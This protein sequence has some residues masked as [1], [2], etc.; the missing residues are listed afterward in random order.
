[1][2]NAEMD[3]E[4]FELYKLREQRR[5]Q[6]SQ[7]VGQTLVQLSLKLPVY[8]K[9]PSGADGL[10]AWGLRQLLELLSQI[11][12]CSHGHDRL[13]PWALL[14]TSIAADRL[15]R[16]TVEL[17]NAHP[18]GLLLDIAVYDRDGYEYKRQGLGLPQRK[19]LI[20]AE[21]AHD[22]LN[23][24][25]HSQAELKARTKKLLAPFRS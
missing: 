13:G 20:C 2:L 24:N 19:C 4:L 7:Q 12:S 21:P 23:G 25:R 11:E 6:V 18:A 8:A 10:F 15:K 3:S 5:L 1:M 14:G 22:C 16:Q 9:L 17:E